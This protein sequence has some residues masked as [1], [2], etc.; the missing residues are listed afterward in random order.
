MEP[1]E[2]TGT[3]ADLPSG[4]HRDEQKGNLPIHI[5][6][7]PLLTEVMEALYDS[8][9]NAGISIQSFWDGGWHWRVSLG[10]ELNGFTAE[11]VFSHQDFK[12]KA[13]R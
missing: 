5:A 2:K 7:A 10:D 9:I 3:A 12:R 8:G 13:A 6:S 1:E 4:P 11:E